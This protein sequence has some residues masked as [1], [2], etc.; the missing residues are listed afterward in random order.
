MVVE[1]EDWFYVQDERLIGIEQ[2]GHINYLIFKEN[3]RS[4]TGYSPSIERAKNSMTKIIEAEGSR[5][6][7]CKEY[8]DFMKEFYSDLIKRNTNK[9]ES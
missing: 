5:I 8:I 1:K 2:Q 6:Y 7:A 4:V 3:Y 9:D